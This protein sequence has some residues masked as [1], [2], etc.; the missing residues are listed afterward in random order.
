MSGRNVS[1]FSD[2]RV[3]GEKRRPAKPCSRDGSPQHASVGI[4]LGS[5]FLPGTALCKSSFTFLTS[6][7]KKHFYPSGLLTASEF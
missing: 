4:I 6:L 2:C 7:R 3:T 1:P 5:L